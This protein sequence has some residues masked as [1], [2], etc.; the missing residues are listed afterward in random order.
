[1]LPAGVMPTLAPCCATARASFATGPPVLTG[2]GEAAAASAAADQPVAAMRLPAGVLATRGGG[3]APAAA[4]QP[5]RASCLMWA[6][7]TTPAC[8]LPPAPADCCPCQRKA[9]NRFRAARFP[10]VWRGVQ[11]HRWALSM[12]SFCSRALVMAR[13]GQISL[14]RTIRWC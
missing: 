10:R 9:V 5:A 1:M 12:H 2:G 3:A 6:S 7:A 11:Q 13:M 4:A 8:D 14:L